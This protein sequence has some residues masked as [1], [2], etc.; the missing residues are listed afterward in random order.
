MLKRKISLRRIPVI[1][2]DYGIKRTIFLS[3]F[4]QGF[5]ERIGDFSACLGRQDKG[6]H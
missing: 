4:G 3:S 2:A 6:G 1:H 5:S